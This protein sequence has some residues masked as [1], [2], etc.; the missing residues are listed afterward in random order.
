MVVAG[1]DRKSVATAFDLDAFDMLV[2]YLRD[3]HSFDDEE[4]RRVD[5]LPVGVTRSGSR[6]TRP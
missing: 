6:V 1:S 4:M 5:S 2:D 3:P